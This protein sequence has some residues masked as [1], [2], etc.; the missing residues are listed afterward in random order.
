[1]ARS[2]HLCAF[3]HGG[4]HTHAKVSV[5]WSFWTMN[6]FSLNHRKVMWFIYFISWLRCQRGAFVYSYSCTGS[7]TFCRRAFL[8]YSLLRGLVLLKHTL[9]F[10]LRV[11]FFLKKQQKAFISD[12]YVKYVYMYTSLKRIPKTYDRAALTR[13]NSDVSIDVFI[14]IDIFVYMCYMW[15]FS[16]NWLLLTKMTSW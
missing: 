14:Y 11:Y 5:F 1:M 8:M 2:I 9:C 13:L 10:L 12:W 4:K 7:I 15:T 3:S 6:S 16:N